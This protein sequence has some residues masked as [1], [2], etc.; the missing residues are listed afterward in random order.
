[1]PRL[2]IPFAIAVAAVVC[3]GCRLTGGGD[4]KPLAT[5]SSAPIAFLRDSGTEESKTRLVIVDPDGNNERTVPVPRGF[6]VETFSWSPDGRRLVFAAYPPSGRPTIFVAN[7]DGTGLRE[8]RRVPDVGSIPTWST[9]GDTIAFDNQDDGYHAIWVVDAD[10]SRARKLTPG[11]DF[12]NPVWSPDGRKIAYR[13]FNREPRD[14]TY[15]MNADGS[16]KSKLTRLP[17]GAWRRA[18]LSYWAREGI[19]FVKPDGSAGAIAFHFSNT[20]QTAELSRDGGAVALSRPILPHG[21]WEL[22]V[23]TRNGVRRLTDNDRED[24]H[25]SFAPDSKSLVFEGFRTSA[26]G[27]SSAPAGD[28]Y[29][30]N[31]D[32]SGERNLTKSATSESYPSWAPDPR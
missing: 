5:R 20:W 13:P 19:G 12:S 18:G 17:T 23:V 27:E 16:G 24:I 2:A 11:H 32:G 25:P 4:P 10:G 1:M 3:G 8:V 22:A 7:A 6:S 28:I 29:V 14:W 21:D 15:V 31:A 30:I 9:R 26:K